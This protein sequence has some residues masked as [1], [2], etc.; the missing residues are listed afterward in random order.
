MVNEAMEEIFL[1]A[2]KNGLTITAAQKLIGVGR[3]WHYER[4]RSNPEWEARVNQWEAEGI[5]ELVN[6]IREAGPKDWKASLELLKRRHRKD[7]GDHQVVENTGEQQR[8]RV[9]IVD[10]HRNPH[11]KKDDKQG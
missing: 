7:Y 9:E 5:K 2:V 10:N 1:E 6:N 11:L 3:N 4:C 8:F